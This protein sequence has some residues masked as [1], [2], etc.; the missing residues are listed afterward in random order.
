MWH[1]KKQ[2]D[3]CG[4]KKEVFIVKLKILIFHYCSK[5]FV[6]IMFY[7]LCKV[8]MINLQEQSQCY[9]SI[10]KSKCMI[11]LF[12]ISGWLD[13][14]ICKNI[15]RWRD[16]RVAPSCFILRCMVENVGILAA[17]SPPPPH[18]NGD[19]CI[20]RIG[21]AHPKCSK[22]ICFKMFLTSKKKQF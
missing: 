10:F 2:L 6:P 16:T 13:Q 4:F 3:L 21:G 20:W 11:I 19:S 12:F 1:P 15:S 14:S 7:I 9:N 18:G 5:H 8:L 17:G 22:R